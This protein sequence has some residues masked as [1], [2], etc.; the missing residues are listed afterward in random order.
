MSYVQ[1]LLSLNQRHLNLAISFFGGTVA[2]GFLILYHFKPDLVNE[3]DFFKIVLFSV[4]LTMPSVLLH[5][6]QI[7][8]Y[9]L[10][11]K[12]GEKDYVGAAIL[13]CFT[14]LFS[15]H[16]ALVGAYI[17][18]WSFREF[19]MGAVASTVVCYVGA[20]RAA[21]QESK[22]RLSKALASDIPSV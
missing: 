8:S 18:D 14:S 5:Y 10:K 3:W 9:G 20:W 15:L 19:L 12:E 13:A 2:P 16:I 7:S 1:D 21:R 6:V 11:T 17:L 4:A 22:E